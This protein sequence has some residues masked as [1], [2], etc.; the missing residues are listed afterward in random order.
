MF[1]IFSWDK[2]PAFSVVPIPKSEPPE[3]SLLYDIFPQ[4]R[5][6]FIWYFGLCICS[7]GPE[8]I[9]WGGARLM[10]P[11]W[12]TISGIWWGG[13][14]SR[15]SPGVTLTR[16]IRVTSYIRRPSHE[17]GHHMG[18]VGSPGVALTSHIRVTLPRGGSNQLHQGNHPMG[19]L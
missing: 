14:D 15:G 11:L 6:W 13:G 8:E 12:Q 3:C 10:P 18:W 19:W 16:H 4:K 2:S 5:V 9:F 1:Y 7:S 17:W